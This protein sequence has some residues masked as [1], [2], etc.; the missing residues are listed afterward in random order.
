MIIINTAGLIDEAALIDALKSGQ[1][2]AAGLDVF[3]KEPPDKTNPLLGFDN[4]IVSPHVGGLSYEAFRSMMVEAMNNMKLEEGRAE[5]LESREAG[6]S[7]GGLLPV[8]V[9][10]IRLPPVRAYAIRCM[11]DGRMPGRLLP[12]PRI[13]YVTCV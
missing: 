6:M 5:E 7:S 10:A 11:Q 3:A 8:H 9:H 13:F 12:A 4:V 2:R 1:V